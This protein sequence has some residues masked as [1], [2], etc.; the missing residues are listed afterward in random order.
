MGWGLRRGKGAFRS[1][2]T[3][4]HLENIRSRILPALTVLPFDEAT[5]EELGS[6]INELDNY[7]IVF[8]GKD[9]LHNLPTKNS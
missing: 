3:D 5:A 1:T 7:K 4:C 6:E 2:H 9:E 8:Q